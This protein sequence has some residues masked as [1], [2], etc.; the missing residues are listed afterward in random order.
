M[1]TRI[2]FERDSNGRFDLREARL[3]RAVARLE[4]ARP[5]RIPEALAT[6]VAREFITHTHAIEGQRKVSFAEAAAIAARER[7]SLLVLSRAYAVPNS[8]HADVQIGG[9]D[10]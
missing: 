7:P 1:T 8:E 2:T 3:E 10:E 5:L 6:A 9:E 4:K